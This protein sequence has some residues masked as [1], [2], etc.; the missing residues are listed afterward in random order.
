MGDQLSVLAAIKLL[1]Q[2]DGKATRASIKQIAPHLSHRH[3]AETIAA[4]AEHIS[5]DKRKA[6]TRVNPAL[7][8]K[9]RLW[10]SGQ[11]YHV[12]TYGAWSVE[13]YCLKLHGRKDL[14]EKLATS[15]VTGAL[16]DS[17]HEKHILDTIE[18]RAALEAEGIKPWTEAVIDDRLW[19]EKQ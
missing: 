3:I 7:T 4:N 11:F 9:T 14:F 16:G 13:G 12:G 15:H 18:N 6:I 10:E 5:M 17:W 2:V 8:L 19:I 1:L